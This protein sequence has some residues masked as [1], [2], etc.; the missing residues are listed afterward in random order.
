MNNTGKYTDQERCVVCGRY[1]LPDEDGGVR[2]I[3]AAIALA[4]PNGEPV[5]CAYE[6]GHTDP[7]SWATL[8]G[9]DK[10]GKYHY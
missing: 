8:P 4:G 9:I 6:P 7:H 1:A 2:D 5:A 3:C 10:A